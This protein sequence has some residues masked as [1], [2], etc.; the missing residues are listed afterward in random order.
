MQNGALGEEFFLSK[1]QHIHSSSSLSYIFSK[2][3][4]YTGYKFFKKFPLLAY[5]LYRW[6]LS[7]LRL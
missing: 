5:V 6:K 2:K 7:L 4:P 3:I 1:L